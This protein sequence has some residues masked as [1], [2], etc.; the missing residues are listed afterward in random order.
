MPQ[1][2]ISQGELEDTDCLLCHQQA[3]KRKKV[4]GV[5]VPDTGAMSISMDEAARTVH[6]PVRNNCLKCHAKAGGGDAVKRGDLILAQA[7]TTDT[8]FDVHMSNTD[9]WNY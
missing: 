4:D 2:E 1:E 9:A 3:Y 6:D 7:A 8:N 5:F